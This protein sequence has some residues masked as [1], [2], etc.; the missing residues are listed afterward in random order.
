MRSRK[1][2]RSTTRTKSRLGRLKS[3]VAPS[4]RSFSE[5]ES[6]M[7]TEGPQGLGSMIK[8]ADEK[9][10]IIEAELAALE[11]AAERNT[12]QSLSVIENRNERIKN[13]HQKKKDQLKSKKK[14]QKELRQAKKRFCVLFW[15]S[16]RVAQKET[17]IVAS[18]VL[19]KWWK[20]KIN[21]GF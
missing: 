11:A 13:L 19:H 7:S 15:M 1:S 16:E 17:F 18:A 12:D 5:D 3:F 2:R 20:I 4:R 14:M 10:R 9:I 6:R 8:Q 21:S